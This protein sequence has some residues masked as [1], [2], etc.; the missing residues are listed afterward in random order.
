MAALLL[1]IC[2]SAGAEGEDKADVGCPLSVRADREVREACC[3]ASWRDTESNRE[4]RDSILEA[5]LSREAAKDAAADV[6]VAFRLETL[7]A[8]ESSRDD[9]SML[10][11]SLM[12]GL[13]FP[14][15]RLMS[16]STESRSRCIFAVPCENMLDCKGA[17][18]D[19]E[20]LLELESREEE[21]YEL[22]CPL[23]STSDFGEVCDS[24]EDG[25]DAL[26]VVAGTGDRLDKTEERFG[27]CELLFRIAT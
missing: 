14:S 24:A 15:S 2:E 5:T 19:E 10:S 25:G 1:K 12:S 20:K 8:L 3:K 21:A 23:C 13:L 9:A 18:R 22:F 16:S 4:R 7:R 6:S 17:R 11:D 26:V 27:A